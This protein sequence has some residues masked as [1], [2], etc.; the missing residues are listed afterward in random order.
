MLQRKLNLK[1]GCCGWSYLK[2]TGFKEKIR[3]PYTSILQ[4][5]VQLFDSVEVNS[6]F[7]RLPTEATVEKWGREAFNKNE[8]FEFAIKAYQGITHI[9]RFSG[10]SLEYYIQVKKITEKLKSH[11]ILF[12]SP[13]NFKPNSENISKIRNFFSSIVVGNLSLAWEPRG[14][15]YDSPELIKELCLE[16]NLIHCVD[17]LR[18]E[19]VGFGT[20]NVAYFRLHGFGKPSVYN[21]SFSHKELEELKQVLYSLARNCNSIYLFFNNS[22]CYN[23]AM[24]FLTILK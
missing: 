20:K 7:Y 17:P 11:L 5:Y 23:N 12:Q 21:Y 10:K 14:D 15:W 24:D 18:N 1:V 22:D 19:P 2:P 3:S 13:A 9:D 16:Y 6:T 4:A 8:N